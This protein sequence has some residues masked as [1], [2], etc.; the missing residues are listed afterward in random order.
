M[1]KVGS[2]VLLSISLFL[3]GA[4]KS[5]DNKSQQE[6]PLK[7]E[8]TEKGSSEVVANEVTSDS[9][10]KGFEGYS[11][12]DGVLT[13]PEMVITI[14]KT[15]VG[16]ATGEDGLI[17]WFTIKNNNDFNIIPQSEFYIFDIKQ[18][19]ETSEYQIDTGFNYVDVAEMLYPR[20]TDDGD[21]VDDETYEKNGILQ[22]EHD[23]TY[24]KKFYAELLPGKEVKTAVGLHLENTEYPVIINLSEPYASE[25]KSEDYVINLK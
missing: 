1:K 18:Q 21:T 2:F 13:T 12:I 20:Y 9:F 15:E 19:D 25:I 24:D 11:F 22:E 4:C 14:D 3:L 6:K 10:D 16:H 5:P 23:E 8:K 7:T 17:V